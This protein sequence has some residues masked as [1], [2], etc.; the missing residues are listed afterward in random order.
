MIF[1]EF[2]SKLNF[3]AFLSCT[4]N[5]LKDG[6]IWLKESTLSTPKIIVTNIIFLQLIFWVIYG[7][8]ILD[9]F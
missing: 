4:Y 7:Q 2:R 6:S 8:N 5:M 9:Y 3:F 1:L